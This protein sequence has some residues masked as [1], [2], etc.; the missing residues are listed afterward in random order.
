MPRNSGIGAAEAKQKVISC[1]SAGMTRGEAMKLVGRTI[2]TFEN[3]QSQDAE[4]RSAISDTKDRRARA[5]EAGKDESVANLGFAEWRKRFLGRE[6]YPHHQQWIDVLEG[7]EPEDLH[8]S[9][10]YEPGRANRL[11]VNTPPFHSKS[12]VITTEYTTYRICM[13]PNI[14]VLVVSQT[15]AK[16]KEFLYSI[17]TMLTSPRFAEMHAAYAPDGG[18][19]PP[20]ADGAVWSQDKIYVAGRGEDAAD[21][22]SKDPTVQALGIRGH[23]YGSRADLIIL[24]DG[25]TLSNAN[26]YE[27]QIKWLNQEVSSRAK[28]GKIVVVGTRVAPMDLYA[29]LREGDNFPSGKSPWTYLG[30]PAVLEYAEHPKDWVTLWPKSMQPLDENGEEEPDEDGLYSAWDG[31]ALSDVREQNLPR[32]WALVYMQQPVA[33]DATFHPTC[34]WGSVDK[35]RKAGPL[36]PGEWGGRRSG[37]EGM[38]VI[39]SID[40][41]GTGEA[42][43]MVYAVDRQTRERWVLDGFMHSG[44]SNTTM[45]FQQIQRMYDEFRISEL[46][47]EKNSFSSWLIND[48]TI[49]DYCRNRGIR[50]MPHY[51]GTNKQDPDFGVAS[52][53]P[54]FG[55]LRRITEGGREDHDKNNL[56]HLPDPGTSP[57]TKAL[58]EQ[59]LS[60]QPGKLGKQLR[61]DGVMCLWFAELR[62]KQVLLGTQGTQHFMKNR[63]LS[64][65][66]ASRRLVRPAVTADWGAHD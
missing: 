22:A 16:A 50:I 7:R 30:Q 48:E 36:R 9:I 8:P 29:F 26:E 28:T 56:I 59:L 34:V 31:P 35:R 10:V 13:N 55:G 6:T 53:A 12:T 15:Q 54:L 21:P 46:V 49:V 58:V 37:M 57:A 66:A 1:I 18:F 64:R 24:D 39:G 33:E 45:Y 47:V 44:A 32:D 2:K 40:P 23:I 19:K 20:R 43:T 4:F 42:Y 51:T 41:A 14:R 11:L 5:L 3:W 61:M 65:G 63:Y 52:M 27:K 17:K 38:H 60:W 25:I 62:A